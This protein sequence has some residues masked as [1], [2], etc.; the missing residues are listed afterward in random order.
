M[1]VCFIF[2]VNQPLFFFSV[3]IYRN[4]DG[5]GIDFIGFFLILKFSFRFQFFHGKQSQIHQADEFVI[6]SFIENLTVR[7][8]LFIRFYDRLFVITVF[9]C[10]FFQFCGKCCMTAV[11]GPVSIQH[12]NFS[13]GR[14]TFFFIFE[15]ILD[16]QEILKCHS[17]IQ[18]IIQLFQRSLFHFYKSVK[19]HHIFRI[20]KYGN[21]CFRFYH[22]G[23]TGIYRVNAVI[24][25]G[26]KFFVCNLSLNDVSGCRFDDRLF[27]LF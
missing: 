26:I 21:Q 3:H 9:E 7:Q 22:I 20:V 4:Y 16:M 15:I 12:T 10:Y 24:L 23:L 8:I 11:I 19:N 5:A 13:H 14:I 25:D 2:K 18:R 1:V 27:V 17:Q 6:S